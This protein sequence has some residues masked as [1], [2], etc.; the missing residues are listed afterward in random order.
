MRSNL[1]LKRRNIAGEREE[2]GHRVR[3]IVLRLA[4]NR[5]GSEQETIMD[6]FRHFQRVGLAPLSWGLRPRVPS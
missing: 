1:P 5:A 4:E 2:N 6:L 3:P